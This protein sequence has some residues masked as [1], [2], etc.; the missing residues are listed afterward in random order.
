MPLLNPL[1]IGAV[2]TTSVPLN[3]LNFV[4]P[5]ISIHGDTGGFASSAQY[6]PVV[7]FFVYPPLFPDALTSPGEKLV[8]I[9][10]EPCIPFSPKV[11]Y[12]LAPVPP[13]EGA[14]PPPTLIPEPTPPSPVLPA[15]PPEP[16]VANK[17]PF[18]NKNGVL[19]VES[20]PAITYSVFAFILNLKYDIPPKP[21]EYVVGP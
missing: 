7:H 13:L 11:A 20:N 16:T 8:K 9:D 2:L 5:G 3:N 4:S 14:F 19:I 15:S 6:F 21:P 17:V 10:A 1:L 18:S 12:F